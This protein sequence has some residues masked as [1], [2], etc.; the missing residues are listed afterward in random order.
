MMNKVVSRLK[1]NPAD[2]TPLGTSG[3]DSAVF[4]APAVPTHL[5]S[6]AAAPVSR[7]DPLPAADAPAHSVHTAAPPPLDDR[8]A[9]KA[10]LFHHSI[11]LYAP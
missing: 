8:Q 9:R 5:I 2:P 11:E 3:K 1:R 4:D 10:A 6:A 7:Q